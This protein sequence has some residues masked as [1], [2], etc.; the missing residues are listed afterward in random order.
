MEEE[1]MILL[2]SMHSNSS[3]IKLAYERGDMWKDGIGSPVML[4]DFKGL[5]SLLPLK[6]VFSTGF[7]MINIPQPWI[8]SL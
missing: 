6:D 3:I 7:W 4:P 8:L 5:G 1:G 2:E